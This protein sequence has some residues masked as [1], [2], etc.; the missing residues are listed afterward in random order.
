MNAKEMANKIKDFME[1]LEYINRSIEDWKEEVSY[2]DRAICDLMHCI[3]GSNL[4][5]VPLKEKDSMLRQIQEYRLRR[6]EAKASLDIAQKIRL[7]P[8]ERDAL[9]E[10]LSVVAE[11]ADVELVYSPRVLFDLFK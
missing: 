11:L 2:S 6:Q 5:S 9:I 10:K 1:V 8:D 3:Q 4:D 7:Y